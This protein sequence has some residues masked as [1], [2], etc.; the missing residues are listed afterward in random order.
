MNGRRGLLAL[1]AI[2]AVGI[3]VWWIYWFASG[4]NTHGD[5]CALAY[6]NSFPIADLV[7]AG[8]I[9]LTAVGLARHDRLGWLGPL[10]AGMALSLAT[11][12]TTHNLLTGGFSGPLLTTVRKA[13][14]AVVNGA[15]GVWTLI[16]LSRNGSTLGA[17]FPLSTSV[18]RGL[19]LLAPVS[20]I[21]ALG[22]L[23]IGDGCGGALSGSLVAVAGAM[24]LA[25]ARVWFSERGAW[26]L[27]GLLLHAG[28]VAGAQLL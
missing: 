13:L 17:P 9:G 23:S 19:V 24:C 7:L 11:L 4:S 14:F 6:E 8:M 20:L 1:Q 10:A 3:V 15:V 22:Y 21:G 26:V 28:L 12:D 25:A 5:V 16:W 2:A 27:L 18:K